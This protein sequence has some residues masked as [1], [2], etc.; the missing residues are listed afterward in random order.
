MFECLNIVPAA[1]EEEIR[2]AL[3]SCDWDSATAVK[4]LQVLELGKCPAEEW[5]FGLKNNEAVCKL[6]LKSTKWNL[7]LAKVGVR[8]IASRVPPSP[9]P[10]LSTNTPELNQP[11][12]DVLES[13]V[14]AELEELDEEQKQGKSSSEQEAGV[15]VLEEVA[16]RSSRL[17]DRSSSFKDPLT[18]AQVSIFKRCK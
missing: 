5:T 12:M 9:C 2:T 10:V 3:V 13:V 7:A 17:K 4:P 18:S 1:T 6:V 8:V 15:K 11:N 14:K 16:K